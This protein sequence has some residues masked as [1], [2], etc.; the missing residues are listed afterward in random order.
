MKVKISTCAVLAGCILAS[1]AF[2][3]SLQMTGKVSSVNDTQV[4]VQCDGATWVIK[5]TPSTTVTPAPTPGTTVTV[6]AKCPDAQRKEDPTGTPTPTPSGGQSLQ[7]RGT[8]TELT[9]T[10][11]TLTCDAETWCVK[12]GRGTNTAVVSGDLVVGKSVTL[13]CNC[14]DAQRKEGPTCFPTA[15]P[16][17]TPTPTATATS[18]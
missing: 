17:P 9:R 13:K 16:K 1:L 10:M 3:Q 5:L 6:Q 11:I 4:E 18:G 15:T 2:A 14:P 8:V 12:R 7:I